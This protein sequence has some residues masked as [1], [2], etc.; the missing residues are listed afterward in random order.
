MLLSSLP[1]VSTAECVGELLAIKLNLPIQLELVQ[2]VIRLAHT[3]S[4]E[5]VV[6]LGITS[7]PWQLVY[8][9]ENISL[10]ARITLVFVWLCY[11]GYNINIY[12]YSP[13]YPRQ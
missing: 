11:H 12:P 6:H 10:E 2:L 3:M 5:H 7:E 8:Q 1:A 9:K 13:L 4:M